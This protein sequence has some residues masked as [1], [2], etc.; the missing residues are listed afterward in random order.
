MAE[1]R[2]HPLGH[3]ADPGRAR[4]VDAEE[5]G[6]S[7]SRR[8]H[9]PG[10]LDAVEAMGIAFGALPLR[11]GG[12]AHDDGRH[13]ERAVVEVQDTGVEAEGLQLRKIHGAD[14]AS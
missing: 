6:R 9:Q 4:R 7:F 12:L 8:R 13:T 3:V 5:P 1:H 2:G 10:H 14:C 11:G